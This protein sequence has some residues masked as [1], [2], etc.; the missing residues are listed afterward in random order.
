MA[1]REEFEQVGQ[2]L[3]RWRS[4]LPLLM[5]GLALVVLRDFGYLHHSHPLDQVWEFACLALSLFGLVIRMATV[6]AAPKGTS[7]RNLTA[8]VAETLNTSGMYSIVR[9]PL[10]VGNFFMGLGVASFLRCWWFTLLYIL[11][12]WLYYER[13]MF[14]EEE[15]LRDKFGRTYLEWAERTPAFVPNLARWRPPSLRF[16]FRWALKREY[17]SFLSLMAAF[18]FLEVVG[19]LFATGK[20]IFDPIWVVIFGSSL[21]GYAVVRLLGKKTT[22]LDRK[23][24]TGSKG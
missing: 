22:W 5:I 9:H 13:I 18:T 14:A 12:F 8:Q 2:W 17:S 15:F 4:Y 10:Y 20:L 6:G 21:L 11:V 7:G 23:K 19:D 1:L 16:S 24:D 3:F